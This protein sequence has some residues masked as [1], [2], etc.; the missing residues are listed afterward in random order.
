MSGNVKIYIKFFSSAFQLRRYIQRKK[1]AIIRA[2]LHP[3]LSRHRFLCVGSLSRAFTPPFILSMLIERRRAGVTLNG[4]F[5]SW[6]GE[7]SIRTSLKHCS[8]WQDKGN[9]TIH[10]QPVIKN[11]SSS[12][13]C[14]ISSRARSRQ[15]SI[16]T[17]TKLHF[18][19][20]ISR[21]IYFMNCII[22]SL[23]ELIRQHIHN[24]SRLCLITHLIYRST[25]RS[26]SLWISLLV[27][28]PSSRNFPCESLALLVI[29]L[30]SS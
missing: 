12:L 10:N 15:I 20:P 30:D 16:L 25:S 23:L 3:S 19:C 13:P 5:V 29:A 17:H 22:R 6:D 24:E 26:Q 28:V 1:D 27:E 8:F 14:F 18:C 2:L 21:S 11:I 7:G 9:I 4:A